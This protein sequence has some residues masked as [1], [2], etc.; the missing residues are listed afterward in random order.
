M[1]P[2]SQKTFNFLII[3][4]GAGIVIISLGLRWYVDGLETTRL[5]REAMAQNE[6][7]VQLAQIRDNVSSLV[8]TTD[9]LVANN[10]TVA[11]QLED[12][13]IKLVAAET[14]RVSEAAVARQQIA[15]L[16][17]NIDATK[18]PDL[19]AI[20]SAWRPRV[21]NLRCHWPLVGNSIVDTS[22][23][24]VLLIGGV[25][26]TLITNLHVISYQNQIAD[27]CTIQFPDDPTLSVVKEID[28]YPSSNGLDWATIVIRRP[29]PY[30]DALASANINRCTVKAS[31]GSAV[32]MLGYPA[33]GDKNDVTA[34]EGII[35]GYDG[36][37]YI[38]SAKV[39]R[40]NSGG[41]AILTKENCYLGMPTFVDAG[42]LETLA[43][44]LDQSYI[45]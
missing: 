19:A 2:L 8:H 12:E 36:N 26:P 5:S 11:K 38:S 10:K 14:Q 32:V 4:L 28:I 34:T 39:E 44:I 25:N 27:Q 40:G 1:N 37:Y 20:I 29:S 31:V 45:K 3:A 21:A 43:R 30:I 22:G 23:S 15:Q 6:I 41:A 7:Q 33:I 9:I 42:Q 17:S 16:Q 35:S 13:K 24:G 18:S